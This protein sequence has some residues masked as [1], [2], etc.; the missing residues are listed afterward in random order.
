MA[1]KKKAAKGRQPR[2][3]VLT[4]EVEG[5]GL[6][7]KAL[8]TMNAIYGRQFALDQLTRRGRILQVQVNRVRA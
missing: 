8:R 1:T 6:T 4:I 5:D 7:C 3:F 2:R